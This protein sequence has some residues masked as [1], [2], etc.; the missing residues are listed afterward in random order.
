MA[1]T[2]ELAGLI[3]RHAGRDGVHATAIP[4]L[5][6]IRAD[7]PT[8]PLHALQKP[9][10]CI[11]ASGA[12]QVMLGDQIF[13]YDRRDYLVAAVDVPVTGQ[14]LDA[15]YLCLR[16]DL[17][18]ALLSGLLLDVEAGDRAGDE[19]DHDM[20]GGLTLSPATPELLD[21]TLRLARLLDT[22]RDIA[23]LAPLA[24]RE[25][26]YRLLLGD[27]AAKLRQI[28]MADSRL[29]KINRAILWIRGHYAEPFSIETVAA[30][31]GMSQ[32][33]LHHHFKVVTAMSPLQYQKQIR[34]QEARRLILAHGMDAASAG[35]IVGY[36]SPSQFSREYSRLFGAPPL[37]DIARLKAMRSFFPEFGEIAVP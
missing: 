3:A 32:S 30:E 26:L 25:I 24:E 16:L 29:Q 6:L 2:D 9:A 27:T 4:R 22:P 5:S 7:A 34:L 33:S 14:V 31:A 13:R 20:P 19:N 28:A 10:L 12:K 17:D 8:E 37:R 11:I 36:E 21:A 18:A 23:A 35:H 1:A 15:P